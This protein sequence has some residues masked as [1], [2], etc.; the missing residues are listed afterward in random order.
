MAGLEDRDGLHR[1][2]AAGSAVNSLPSPS[3]ELQ[4]SSSSPISEP[5][6]F[7]ADEPGILLP[8]AWLCG[9]LTIVIVLL[10]SLGCTFQRLEA[11][12]AAETSHS[13]SPVS[14]LLDSQAM[15]HVG[16]AVTNLS[17]SLSFYV[18]ALGG[19]EVSIANK[20]ISEAQ[21]QLLLGGSHQMGHSQKSIDAS[22]S[23]IAWRTV[24]FGFSQV[25]LWESP[26]LAAF[27][28]TH[29]QI[30]FR[31]AH[32]ANVSGFVDLIHE[33]LRALPDLGTSSCTEHSLLQ[34]EW[35]VVACRGPDDEAVQFWQPSL[36]MVQ[37]FEKARKEWVQSASDPRGRD[38]FE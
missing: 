20:D 21:L 12:R 2:R 34:P 9:S 27:A 16:L 29:M 5:Q 17:R 35:R 4:S 18:G 23:P 30:A 32:A 10:L 15:H 7:V 6:Q 24:S 28:A 33:R 8:P 31:L 22:L 37:L 14:R 19:R 26:A 25:V 3:E 38:L 11:R 1:R 36:D 13:S